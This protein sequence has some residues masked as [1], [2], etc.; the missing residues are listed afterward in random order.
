[1]HGAVEGPH[2][3]LSFGATRLG[4][5][6]F[7]GD[8][9]AVALSVS[10]GVKDSDVGGKGMH[11]RRRDARSRICERRKVLRRDRTP[12]R[13][14][15]ADSGG[16]P[17]VSYCSRHVPRHTISLTLDLDLVGLIHSISTH[18]PERLFV[19]RGKG[20]SDHRR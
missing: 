8:L 2:G 1:M 19:N 6:F 5:T 11:H 18:A 10:F 12:E 7:S 20:T 14:H 9:L 16:F 13:L 4:A 15:T 17:C 3:L